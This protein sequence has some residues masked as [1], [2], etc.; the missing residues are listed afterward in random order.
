MRPVLSARFAPAALVAL[1]LP[2]AACDSGP[3]VSATNATQAEV[4]EKVAAATAGEGVT[5]QPGR[6]EGAMTMHEMDMPG[7]PAAAKA[8]MQAQMKRTTSFA[9]CVTPEDVKEQ[10]AFFTGDDDKSCK[11][12]HFNMAGGKVDAAMS[13]NRADQG[14]MAMTMTGSYSPE[15]YQMDMATRMEGTGPMSG[16]SMKM[17]VAAKRVG[18]CKGTPDEL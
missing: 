5:I 14:K 7:L 10:R 3:S 17:S 16:M 9:N 8:Q 6:W 13:C 1:V 15:S 2:L 18:V 11:Y 12:D 4:Q